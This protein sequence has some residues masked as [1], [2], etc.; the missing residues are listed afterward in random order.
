MKNGGSVFRFLS[1]IETMKK[2]I[3]KI[4]C[5]LARLCIIRHKPFVVGITG[6]FGKTTAR[7]VITEV[8]RRANRDV[9]TPEWNYNG[10]WGFAFS[11]LQI[12]SHGRNI[13]S[14]IG[15]FFSAISTIVRSDY[16]EILVLEYGVDHVGEMDIQIN[17]VE[18]DIILFTRLSPSHIE[19][20]GTVEAY[21]AEKEKVLRRAHKKTYAIGNADDRKQADFSCQVWYGTDSDVSDFVMS[22]I[23]EH[24]DGLELD[25][26]FAGQEYHIVS[27]ILWEHHAGILAGAFLVAQKM[28]IPP[29]EIISYMRH[30]HLPHARWNVLKW[31][32]ESLVIDGTYNGWFE[33]IVAGV[34]M[35]VRLAEKESRKTIALI[36][37]MRELGA[38]EA[39]RH[40][41]LWEKLS[42]FPVDYYIFV[43]AVCMEIIQPMVKESWREKTFF[44]LDSRVAGEYIRSLITSD[45]DKFLLFAKGS[46]NTIYLEEALKYFIFPEEYLKLARQDELYTHKKKHF[47]TSHFPDSEAQKHLL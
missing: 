18:P 39:L 20:F 46:Q 25:A 29:L 8:L 1:R 14:W 36:G 32:N 13:L 40:R 10:E 24:P 34:E 28:E 42:S 19:G 9:W 16:P 30:I 2:L 38:L 17:I 6:S 27:P 35:L 37:D 11:V 22:D 4:F 44:T 31:I 3:Q 45:P 15:M 7:H 43:G 23:L 5:L 41:E 47:Y 26:L 33:P 21:Y 12:R